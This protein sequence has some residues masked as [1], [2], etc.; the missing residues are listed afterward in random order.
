MIFFS[1][2]DGTL[3]IE[4]SQLTPHFFEIQNYLNKRNHELVIVSGRSLS[5]GHFFLTHFPF[6]AC[7]MEGGGVIL[8]IDENGEIAQEN[9]VPQEEIDCLAR[10]SEKLTHH[11]PHVPLSADSFGRLTDRAIEFKLMEEKWVLDVMKFMDQEKINYAR[12]NVHIN[13]WCGTISK[14]L[15]KTS[16]RCS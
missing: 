7:I 16:S 5:W 14:Y 12:S 11:F 8:Y 2:F 13:F 4:G 6:K 15:G 10:F 9:L 1:D 3:T